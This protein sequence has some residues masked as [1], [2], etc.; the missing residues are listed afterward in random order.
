MMAMVLTLNVI[1]WSSKLLSHTWQWHGPLVL[2]LFLPFFVCSARF[3]PLPFSYLTLCSGSSG[4]RCMQGLFW[5]QPT[6]VL[7]E[8]HKISHVAYRRHKRS[9]VFSIKNGRM[10][11]GLDSFQSTL[12][13]ILT[14]STLFVSKKNIYIYIYI[15][16]YI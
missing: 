7:G 1:L 8:Q 9:H 16:I 4:L 3:P 6:N 10:R 11:L 2:F 5:T 15:Y 13:P 14:L 12:L